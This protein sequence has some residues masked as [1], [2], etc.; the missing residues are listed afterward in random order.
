MPQTA[1][2]VLRA[3]DDVCIIVMTVRELIQVDWCAFHLYK[4]EV[5]VSSQINT[6]GRGAQTVSELCVVYD[7]CRQTSHQLC[8][9]DPAILE[10]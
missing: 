4:D 5:C 10:K 8:V 6:A 3:R 1:P 2:F 7:T 9:G